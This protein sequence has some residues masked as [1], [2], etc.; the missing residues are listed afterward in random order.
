[1]IPQKITFDDALKVVCDTIGD[2][3]ATINQLPHDILRKLILCMGELDMHRLVKVQGCDV[4]LCDLLD[5]LNHAHKRM[6]EPVYV[7]T[8]V[9]CKVIRVLPDNLLRY[10]RCREE[11]CNNRMCGS[12]ANGHSCI[13]P[14]H[15]DKCEGA[16]SPL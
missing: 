6:Y 14:E 11:N 16:K 7:D 13:C 10:S 5:E 1:M 12:C 8:C 2:A 4:H 9:Y 15:A 3:P